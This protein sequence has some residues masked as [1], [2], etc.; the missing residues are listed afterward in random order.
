MPKSDVDRCGLVVYSVQ[1]VFGSIVSRN[2]ALGK[3]ENFPHVTT[4]LTIEELKHFSISH[5]GNDRSANRKTED[6][7]VALL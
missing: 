6:R 4:A 1:F 5:I 2:I 3:V 7:P